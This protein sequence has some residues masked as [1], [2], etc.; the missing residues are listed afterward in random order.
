MKEKCKIQILK[1]FIANP[2]PILAQYLKWISYLAESSH[3]NK[4]NIEK[5]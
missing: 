4:Y 5:E 3:K 1:A 2:I